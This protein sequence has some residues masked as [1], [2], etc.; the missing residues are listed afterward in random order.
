VTVIGKL[1][2]VGSR[3]GL[4]VRDER[5]RRRQIGFRLRVE[6]A[7]DCIVGTLEQVLLAVGDDLQ[8]LVRVRRREPGD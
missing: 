2:H 6:T 5:A 3:E 8:A 7:V 1:L 4:E